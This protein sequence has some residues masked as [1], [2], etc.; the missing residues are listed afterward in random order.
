MNDQTIGKV[1]LQAGDTELTFRVNAL[2]VDEGGLLNRL[3]I[4]SA[5]G[6]STAIKSLRASLSSK[7]VRAKLRPT[8]VPGFGPYVEIDKNPEGYHVHVSKLCRNT[9]HLMALADDP[10]LLVSSDPDTVWAAL[11][12]DH[13]TTPIIRPWLPWLH[14]TLLQLGSG[15]LRRVR[16]FG[17]RACLL[18][19]DT[20]RLDELVH[21]G[22][23]DG[24]LRFDQDSFTG[25][26]SHAA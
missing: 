9:W 11:C 25:D 18:E 20:D 21:Y 22:V 2:A 16:G 24:H 19:V 6:S 23:R 26:E 12:R 15:Y 7:K 8:D 5:A 17:C 3:L 14:D 1:K 4:L 13:L 10:G